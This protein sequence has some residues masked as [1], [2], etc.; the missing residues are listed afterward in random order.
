MSRRQDLDRFY[1][2]LDDLETT[3]GGPR[4]LR[5]CDG[6]MRWP[7][8]GLYVFFHPTES[9]ASSDQRRVTR[10]GTHAV[11]AG[12]DTTLW[13]R[14]PTHRG[15]RRG[16][17]ASGRHHHGPVITTRVG[18]VRHTPDSMRDATPE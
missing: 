14:L 7:D 4:R 11:S 8:R 18:E 6:R 13:T 15:A 10:I 12:G 9:R 3:V 5:D 17:Y 16:T 1:A 2:L